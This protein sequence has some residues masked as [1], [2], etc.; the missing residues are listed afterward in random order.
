MKQHL[1]CCDWGTTSFRLRLVDAND[2]RILAGIQSDIG[3]STTFQ[4]WKD[5]GQDE[6]KRINFYLQKLNTQILAL[7]EK[8][9]VALEN[10][11]V[12][13]SGMASSTI[14]MEE[15]EYAS[16]PFPLDGSSAS[17]RT[18]NSTNDFFHQFTLVS[19]VRTERDVMRGEETQIVGLFNLP[20]IT[21]PEQSVF[22]FPGTHS[23]H[24]Q[25]EKK[26][27]T[28]FQTFMTG[29]IFSLLSERSILKDSIEISSGSGLT[30]PVNVDAFKLGVK[31]SGTLAI[32]H[33]LFTVRTNQLFNKLA[34]EQNFF[35]LSGLLIGTELRS[36]LEK[37][38][39][40]FIICS[41][42]NLHEH[43]KLAVEEI[44][45][46]KDTIFIPPQLIDKATIAGQV[47]I[48]K[49]KR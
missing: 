33:S 42:N 20:E 21:F 41:G 5:Q 13:L 35:Y 7:G 29:E 30:N 12:I 26:V 31:T 6:S 48:F 32:L 44:G 1:L 16:V 15:I 22:I 2:Y 47:K 37:D 27:I 49:G 40:R 43:Y 14:G 23:K 19:G 46:T 25:V 11:P 24:I 10:I 45:L 18:F 9:S 17:V 28:D 39:G 8:S 36:L 38:A 4:S 3:I 34:K